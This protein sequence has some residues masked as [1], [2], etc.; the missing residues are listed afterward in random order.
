MRAK[1]AIF[2]LDGTLL[3]TLRDLA[4][5][6]NEALVR[7]GLPTHE[8]S[9]YKLFVGNGVRKLF[10]RVL[11]EDKRTPEMIQALRS[12]FMPYYEA[13]V[14]DYTVAYDGI[15]TLLQTL[16]REG[17]CI[18]VASN[19][20]QSGTASLILSFF[21][22]IEF[23]CIYGQRENVPLK[24]DPAVVHE[25]WQHAE[26]KLST[27][28][29]PEEVY[30]LGDSGVDMETACRA[31]VHAIGVT[32]GFRSKEELETNGSEVCIDHPLDLLSIIA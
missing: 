27:K 32:W 29:L 7:C 10:E 3:D 26:K 22:D 2:D 17:V 18:A 12:Y 21:P 4:E 23:L 28:I 13:H 15:H 8:I 16:Q 25:I 19:K 24:P 11:P 1:L 14:S 20:F 31:G 5:A 30:Y 9:A 6:V